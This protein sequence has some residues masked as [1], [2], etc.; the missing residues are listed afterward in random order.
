MKKLIWLIISISILAYISNLYVEKRKE[1]NAK[2]DANL[3]ESKRIEQITKS[4]VAKMVSRTGAINNWESLLNKGDSFRFDPILTIELEKL[5]LE[6][7]PI[8]FIGVIKDIATY[9][10]SYYSV[11][12]ERSVF[13]S[14]DYIMNTELHLSLLSEKEHIDSFLNQ[15]PNL[16]KNYGLNSGIAVIANLESIRTAYI[17]GKE[18]KKEEVKIGEGKLVDMLFI[19]DVKF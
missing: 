1:N 4:A 5:W 7:K 18:G 11:L 3:A 2:N 12:V 9:N 6:N 17:S 15:N 13:N 10:D 16:F 14:F 8:L 19:G